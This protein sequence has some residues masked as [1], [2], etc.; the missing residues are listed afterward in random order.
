MTDHTP[1]FN[2][3]AVMHETGLSAEVLRA[4]ERRYGLPKPQRTSG[5]HRLY[6]QYDID[7]L[8]WLEARQKEG[9]SISRAVEMWRRTEEGGQNPLK[10][11]QST[12]PELALS[13]STLDE[14]R[15]TWVTA[16]LAFDDQAA[17]GAL[18]QA[19][20]VVSPETACL[21]V[22]QKGL[23]Q[24]GDGWY[25]GAM[26]AQQEHFASWLAMRKINALLS[27]TPPP[28]R[29]ERILAACP[30]GEEHAF[31][32]LLA[33]FL[34]R[35]RGWDVVYLG[36]N[37]PLSQLD[38]TL[39]MIST[40]LVITAAQTLASAASLREMADYVNAHGVSIAYGGGIF[41]MHPEITERIPG[42]Y[43]GNTIANLP[44]E[45]EHLL[46]QF[47]PLPAVKPIP[48]DYTQPLA[49]YK[50][51]ESIIIA[52]VSQALPPIMLDYHYLETANEQFSRNIIAA[53]SLG[54]INYL[55]TSVGWLMGFLVNVGVSPSL[56]AGYFTAYRQAVQHYLGDQAE[57]ILDWFTRIEQYFR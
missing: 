39:S 46:S 49:K 57:P 19:F 21:D 10:Q 29:P 52:S 40:R 26:S 15:K 44:Q 7:L 11:T 2:L 5:G 53:L 45:V 37:V 31:P 50:E 16:C 3:K 6:S 33:A 8:K 28:V 55:D 20:A 27:A 12:I 25:Q 4:W 47:S 22:I 42:Y 43:L 17:E 48:L 51:N 41:T 56:A 54:D 14:L 36:A 32:L 35:R 30:P 18:S 38:N 9:L 1:V 34:L 23:S 24:I 13:G